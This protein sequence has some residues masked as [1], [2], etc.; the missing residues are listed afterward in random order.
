MGFLIWR[1]IRDRRNTIIS[2]SLVTLL[3]MWMYVAMFPSLQKQA[4]NFNELF[5]SY[6][7]GLME[8]FGAQT[9]SFDYL[10]TYLATETF[11]FTWPLLVVL[12]AV[13]FA[14]TGIAADIER[15]SV[16]ILLSRPISRFR[17]YIGR[18]LAAATVIVIL[19][20][21]AVFSPLMF[22]SF[23]GISF[24]ASAFGTF[25]ILA[26]L[27]GL[28]V[29]SVSFVIS[30][31]CSDKGRAMSLAG[32]LFVF[33]YLANIFGLLSE[34]VRWMT[35]ISYFKYFD[36]IEGLVHH[37]LDAMPLL[38]FGGSILLATVVGAWW[39]QRRD[40]AT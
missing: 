3:L 36:P 8:A 34:K 5:K 16:E 19:T 33:M 21:I 1:T 7:K 10:D 26:L 30:A 18:Y 14:A 9:N 38:I 13:S 22:A 20:A 17:V 11:N 32:G 23:Q 12:I 25:F 27:Y 39:Y 35:N 2:Y 6:P 40:I 37:H 31:F 28:A 24:H 29:V 4:E 15:G